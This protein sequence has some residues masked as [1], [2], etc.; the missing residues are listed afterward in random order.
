L[1]IIRYLFRTHPFAFLWIGLIIFS[2]IFATSIT[3]YDPNKIDLKN[4]IKGFSLEHPFGTDEYGRDLFTRIVYGARSVIYVILSSCFLSLLGGTILGILA[5]Y[6]GKIIDLVISRIFEILQS[7]PSILI[8][9][10]L[11]AVLGPSLRVAILSVGLFGVPILGRIVRGSTL[12]I[13]EMEYTQANRAV[14]AS[15]IHILIKTILPN[16]SGPIIIQI[17]SI[18]PRAIISVAGLSFLGLG[19]QPPSPDWGAM[20]SYARPY[21]YQHPMYLIIVISV[22]SITIISLNLLGDALRDFFSRHF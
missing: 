13:K 7:F 14:G 12:K 1:N 15:D 18:A 21:M 17:S 19:A 11:A 20:I 22:L 5:G 3:D 16:V 10:M 8:G 4:R 2:A 6:F 9:I